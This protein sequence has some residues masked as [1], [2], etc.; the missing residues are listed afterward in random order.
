MKPL[1]MIAVVWLGC[2][3]AWVSLGGTIVSRTGEYSESLTEEVHALW[4][5]PM[6]QA[7]PHATWR[8]VRTVVET[9]KTGEDEAGAPVFEAVEREV[10]DEHPVA[11]AS[12]DVTVG[13]A[14]EH[15]R[16]GL[17]WF[18]TY[19]VELV[20]R[21]S[22]DNPSSE[23][24]RLTFAFPLQQRHA[25][26]DGFVVAR[27]DGTRVQ[28]HVGDGV[29]T[30]TDELAP[31]QRG[32]YVVSF[33]SR[34]TGTWGYRLTDGTGQVEQFR[35]AM[36][37][38][39]VDVDFPAGSLSPSSHD[40]VDGGWQGVW[41]FE[42]LVASASI[43]VELPRR[44]N[45]GQLASRMTFFAPVALLFFFFVV[46]MLA[47]AGG[48]RIHPLNYMFF[49]CAFFA[50]HL[51]FAYLVDHVAI[52]T[53]FAVASVVSI[54]LVVSYGRLFVGWDFAVRRIGAAQLIYLVLFSYTFF[55]DGFTG[56]AIT[57][58]AVATLF[59]LMQATGRTNWAARLAEARIVREPP[60][61]PTQ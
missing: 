8:E 24:A 26:Y 53:S 7:P 14:L 2:A 46:A 28:T 42:T 40:A 29:A 3:L 58:G 21:Y 49:G 30:W 48:H 10:T 37:T 23:T 32:E 51:L 33:R 56:L 54:G 35:L 50:F 20:G 12:S 17:L 60:A 22:W 34:G 31:G 43:G 44:L 36:T 52:A 6:E 27:R 41:E 18:P 61:S 13:L 47:E 25:I 38:D 1:V 55:W 15:R 16:K 57:I 45:P 59:V 5:Q 19:Q 4:G 11:L 39:F 9:E